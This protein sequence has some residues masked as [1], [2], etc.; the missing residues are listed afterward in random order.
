MGRTLLPAVL[1]SLAGSFRVRWPQARHLC[2]R[3]QPRLW[4]SE[5]PFGPCLPC[6]LVELR[7]DASRPQTDAAIR[8]VRVAG[9][10]D[11]LGSSSYFGAGTVALFCP[12]VPA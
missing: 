2:C 5:R 1:R 6:V 7:L 11:S 12:P 3:T 8:L 9:F 10:D 4:G